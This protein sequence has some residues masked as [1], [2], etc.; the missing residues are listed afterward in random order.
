MNPGSDNSHNPVY[1]VRSSGSNLNELRAWSFLTGIALIVLR[2]AIALTLLSAVADRFGLWGPPG[3]VNVSWGDWPHFVAYTAKV[4]S[5]VP[6]SLTPALAFL[7]T[8]AETLLA[9][10]LIFGIFPR[11]VAFASAALFVFFAAAMTAS[12][13]VKAPL[14]FSVFVDAAAAFA[15]GAWPPKLPVTRTNHHT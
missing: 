4:N 1:T 13:G 12:F 15:I 5:F 7:A 8:A 3:T 2:W 6:S 9:F 14:N 10:A 11:L